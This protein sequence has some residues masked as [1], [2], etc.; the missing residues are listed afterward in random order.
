VKERLLHLWSSATIAQAS[1]QAAASYYCSI[2][3]LLHCYNATDWI[4]DLQKE[5]W[6]L[7]KLR[8]FSHAL[9]DLLPLHHYSS[10]LTSTV[11][12]HAST[13]TSSRGNVVSYPI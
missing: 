11:K 9:L 10:L 6:M 12:P 1:W 8:N 5:T 2:V 3:A 7:K 4:T 13:Q